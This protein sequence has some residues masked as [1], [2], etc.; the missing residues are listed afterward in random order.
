M[1][2]K[3]W[4]FDQYE[5][6]FLQKIIYELKVD[7][8]HTGHTTSYI[9]CFFITIMHPGRMGAANVNPCK[10]SVHIPRATWASSTL[11]PTRADHFELA[12]GELVSANPHPCI[13]H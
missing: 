4:Q 11:I 1:I 13:L 10:L 8:V 6:N 12:M 7:N 9:M 3:T 2:P 5:D